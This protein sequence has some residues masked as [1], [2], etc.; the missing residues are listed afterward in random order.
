M[1]DIVQVLATYDALAGVAIGAGLTYGFGA[2][3][4]RH[5]EA[6]EDRTRWYQARLE[7]YAEFYRALSDRWLLTARDEQTQAD[8][9]MVISKL[10]NALGLIQLIGSVEVFLTANAL[11]KGVQEGKRGGPQ[12]QL[13]GFVFA[14][15]QDL[16]YPVPRFLKKEFDRLLLPDSGEENAG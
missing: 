9:E 8:Y 5:Q 15:R 11:F 16:G 7:A 14:A 4:R 6:R 10:N 2:L 13:A 3:N 1:A 12:P